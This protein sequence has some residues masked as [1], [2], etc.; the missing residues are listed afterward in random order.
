[1]SDKQISP[2]KKACIEN[3]PS[4]LTEKRYKEV[5][6]SAG[7]KTPRPRDASGRRETTLS[8]IEYPVAVGN[9]DTSR[10]PIK[11]VV[12]HTTVGTFESAAGS[13]NSPGRQAS[14]TYIIKLD[15]QIVLM[16][17]EY[18]TPYTNGNYASNQQSITIEHVDNG[19]YNGPRTP[20]LYEAS[21]RLVA[22]ICKYYDLPINRTTIRK[23][24]EVTLSSTACPDSLDVDRIVR[25]A[26][27]IASG[28][29]TPSP[30]TSDLYRVTYKGKQLGAFKENPITK[31]DRLTVRIK[32]LESQIKKIGQA[33][34][35]RSLPWSKVSEVKHILK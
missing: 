14:S 34:G 13:F 35:K 19:N 1:M 8:H 9:Y 29:V 31:I 21:A 26:A 23:H 2:K 10:K 16:L 18:Y 7:K 12:L 17:E 6:R 4:G 25:D 20:Q 11:N 22:D 15:G 3:N 27:N 5:Q 33:I 30:S 28:G 32:E 24:S